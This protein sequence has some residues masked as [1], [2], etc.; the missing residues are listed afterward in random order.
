ML[1]H[2]VVTGGLCAMALTA[3]G[4]GPECQLTCDE[5]APIRGSFVIDYDGWS[6]RVP[7]TAIDMRVL[8]S[9]EDGLRLR[10][11]GCAAERFW[12][13]QFGATAPKDAPR[14]VAFDAADPDAA[15][16]SGFVMSCDEA[17]CVYS[18]RRSWFDDVLDPVLLDGVLTAFDAERGVFAADVTLTE[19]IEPGPGSPSTDTLHVTADFTWTPD[20]AVPLRDA[21]TGAP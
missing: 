19:H 3:G 2:C 14:P 20:S 13:I 6:G 18:R 11:C 1:R 17:D 16:A 5:G 8:G 9:R 12:W 15:H 7:A 4:C 10:G 21:A